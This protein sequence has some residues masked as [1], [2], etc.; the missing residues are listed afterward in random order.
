[1][2]DPRPIQIINL[3]FRRIL[4]IA[5]FLNKLYETWIISLNE[6]MFLKMLTNVAVGWIAGLLLFRI[7]QVSA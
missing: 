5:T 7:R 3:R 1:M 4:I 2:F 6:E